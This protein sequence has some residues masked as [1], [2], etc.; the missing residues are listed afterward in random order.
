MNL[1]CP[2]S[3]LLGLESEN[4]SHCF[5]TAF[6]VPSPYIECNKRQRLPWGGLIV[7]ERAACRKSATLC[8]QLWQLGFRKSAESPGFLPPN[9]TRLPQTFR[10]RAVAPTSTRPTPKTE[11]VVLQASADR[12]LSWYPAG[13][14]LASS[15]FLSARLLKMVVGATPQ[16]YDSLGFARAGP[17]QVSRPARLAP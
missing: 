10:G 17:Q 12:A 5:P 3:L 11:T 4:P 7:W 2:Y 9:Q 6:R 8:H 16:C 13:F 1:L 14:C 15:H